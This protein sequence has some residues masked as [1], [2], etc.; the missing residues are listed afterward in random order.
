MSKRRPLLAIRFS[1]RYSGKITSSV[2]DGVFNMDFKVGQSVSFKWGAKDKKL[3]GTIL[4]L[5][6]NSVR[7]KVDFPKKKG[8][9]V[10]RKKRDIK[11]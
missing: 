7:L 8:A 3:T 11:G 6:P 1:R 9:I 10:V 4:E 2:L 5:H